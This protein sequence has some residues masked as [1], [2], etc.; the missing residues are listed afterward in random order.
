MTDDQSWNDGKTEGTFINSEGSGVLY[1]LNKVAEKE[2][3]NPIILDGSLVT[4][5]AIESKIAKANHLSRY[6]H[7]A[8]KDAIRHL[9]SYTEGIPEEQFIQIY[10]NSLSHIFKEEE[11]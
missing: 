8:I 3:Q 1:A 6:S 10:R 4:L 2:Q 9:K 7:K 5:Y 11:V